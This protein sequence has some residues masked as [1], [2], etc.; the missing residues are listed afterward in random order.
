MMT[1]LIDPLNV[2]LAIFAT[3]MVIVFGVLIALVMIRL[4]GTRQ[5]WM[6][7][8]KWYRRMGQTDVERLSYGQGEYLPDPGVG[9]VSEGGVAG[10]AEAG[11]AGPGLEKPETPT[12]PGAFVIGIPRDEEPS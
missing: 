2:A 7:S 8:E 12:E 4:K 9:Q 10:G 6:S 5:D 11:T 1:A 3:L